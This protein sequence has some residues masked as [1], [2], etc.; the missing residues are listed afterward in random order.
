M[1]AWNVLLGKDCTT[2]DSRV[3]TSC[4]LVQDKL[5]KS[6]QKSWWVDK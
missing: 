5:I 6:R 1:S 4:V 3:I 2:Y